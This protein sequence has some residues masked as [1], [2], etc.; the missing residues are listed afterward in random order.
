MIF[1]SILEEA[2]AAMLHESASYIFVKS[3]DGRYLAASDAF[4]ALFGLSGGEEIAGKYDRELVDNQEHAA[5]FAA[6]DDKFMAKGQ[7]LYDIIEPNFTAGNS[8][9]WTSTSK[10][11]IFGKDGSIIGMLAEGHETGSRYEQRSNY[12]YDLRSVIELSP[13]AYGAMICD[14]TEGT[15]I[16]LQNRNSRESEIRVGA[17]VSALLRY[18]AVHISSLHAW[19]AD[20][21]KA[22]AEQNDR[23]HED[24]IELLLTSADYS[25][26]ASM[27]RNNQR[28]FSIEYYWDEGADSRWVRNNVH[29]FTNPDSGH[30]LIAFVLH[31]I[32][33]ERAD[34]DK[35]VKQACRDS[36]T[37]LLNHEETAR[38]IRDSQARRQHGIL[39]MLDIDDFKHVNDTY[40]HPVGDEVIVSVGRTIAA[41]FR[42]YDIIGRVGGDEFM[43]YA[44]D[45][46]DMEN[47]RIKAEALIRTIEAL[48][49]SCPDC[50]I[51]I[52]VG[53]AKHAE[54][55]GFEQLYSRTD[56]M[57]YRSKR[58]GKH[59]VAAGTDP[60]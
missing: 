42:T 58:T 19:A 37:G 4:A 49:F 48:T 28:E 53:I 55:E 24:A 32:G 9:S 18:A 31:D 35:L 14:L 12:E 11:P 25:H 22:A 40:G 1:L 60:L 50:R 46:E 15:I 23:L 16:E 20:P 13:H 54:N 43:V 59:R 17:P 6:A 10:Y 57:L 52:S 27:Y 41:A 34:R 45:F 56:A 2:F 33:H 51:S 5:H 38:Q 29:I 21:A 8:V 30:L 3:R 44:I 7:P 47:A 26:I 36:L 39:F